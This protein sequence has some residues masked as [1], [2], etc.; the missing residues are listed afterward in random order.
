MR[1]RTGELYIDTNL[2]NQLRIGGHEREQEAARVPRW[3]WVAAL[4]IVAVVAA[5]GAAWWL[6]GARPTSVQVAEAVVPAAGSP[7][8][9]VLQATGYVTA[10][11]QATVSAQ[12]TGTLT[13]VLIEEGASVKAGQVIAQLED[14]ALRAALDVARRRRWRRRARSSN[15]R[16]RTRAGRT[17]SSRRAW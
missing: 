3:L 15:R 16:R 8:R 2:L 1:A 4:V 11:R 17:N 10:H 9:A 5:A 7:D 13:K 12:I 14:S 6:I